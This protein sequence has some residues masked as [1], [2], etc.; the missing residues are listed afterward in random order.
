MPL[1]LV[2][3]YVLAWAMAGF[4]ANFPVLRRLA[5]RLDAAAILESL[6]LVTE[7]QRPLTEGIVAMAI[8][9]PKDWVRHRL[10]RVL[11]AVRAGVNWIDSLRAQRLIRPADAAVLRAAER[12]GNLPWALREVAESNRRRFDYRVYVLLQW[13]FP[14]AILLVGLTVAVYAAACFTPLVTLIQR[15]A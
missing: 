14:L 3:L 13:L 1:F 9:Y 4:E 6:A 7:R 10:D 15:M 11:G 12:V 8:H 5:A 2:P